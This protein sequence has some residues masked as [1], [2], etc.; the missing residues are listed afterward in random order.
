MKFTTNAVYSP[1]ENGQMRTNL[2]LWSYSKYPDE[3]NNN[4]DFLNKE[5]EC[6]LNLKGMD[7]FDKYF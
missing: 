1:Q 2:M 4:N 5:S 3:N 6:Q 7:K